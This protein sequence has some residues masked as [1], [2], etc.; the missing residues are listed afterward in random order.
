[1]NWLN[2]PDYYINLEDFIMINR[3]KHYTKYVHDKLEIRHNMHISRERLKERERG[4][5]PFL[6]AE[7]IDIKL[8]EVVRLIYHFYIA[9][10]SK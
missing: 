1:M 8:E 9:I 7:C 6:F 5:Q 3:Q 2:A 10:Y 4:W